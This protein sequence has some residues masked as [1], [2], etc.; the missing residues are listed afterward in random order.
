MWKSSLPLV[1]KVLIYFKILDAFKSQISSSYDN[2]PFD[3][4][5]F[6]IDANRCT[7][8]EELPSLP[9]VY[10]LAS[11][12]WWTGLCG[13][14]LCSSPP[15]RGLLQAVLQHY[16]ASGG[17][18]GTSCALL[19]SDLSSQSAHFLVVNSV[20]LQISCL[21]FRSHLDCLIL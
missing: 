4:N 15:A 11:L 14:H 10:D 19:A 1:Q 13:L 12:A 6:L 2:R 17:L 18:C 20:L 7:D 21:S 9:P 16:S 5:V 8:C 3:E